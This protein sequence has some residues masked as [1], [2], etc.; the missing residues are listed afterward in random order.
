MSNTLRATQVEGRP[1]I[2]GLLDAMR[3]HPVAVTAAGTLGL[4]A[5]FALPNLT[6]GEQPGADVCGF[7]VVDENDGYVGVVEEATGDAGMPEMAT[8]QDEAVTRI[9][10]IKEGE[11]LH[12]GERFIMY[13]NGRRVLVHTIVQVGPDINSCADYEAAQRAASATPAVSAPATPQS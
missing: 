7:S 10:E 2:F 8:N 1:H 5:A 9:A 6:L 3:R 11:E 13:V 12:P 4:A